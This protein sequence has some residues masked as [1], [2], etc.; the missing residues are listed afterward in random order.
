M[1]VIVLLCAQLWFLLGTEAF[2]IPDE[3]PSI[4]SVI[5]SNIPTIKKGTDS[6]LGWGFRLGDRA[7]FQVMVELGPQTNTQPLANQGE[8]NNRKRNT[9]EN[10]AETLYAQRELEKQL[11]KTKPPKKKSSSDDNAAGWLKSWS[12]SVGRGTSKDESSLLKARPGLAIGE[13][14]AKSVIPE[15]SEEDSIFQEKTKNFVKTMTSTEKSTTS[16]EDALD[17]VD[18]D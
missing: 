2:I 14:D 6:R 4:L 13:I 11:L 7:D 17:N 9:L 12:K 10:L 5:Y 1:K 15:D 3:L 16:K 18:L 8:E